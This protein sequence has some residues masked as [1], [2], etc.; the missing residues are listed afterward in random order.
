MSEEKIEQKQ[1]AQT[2]VSEKELKDEKSLKDRVWDSLKTVMEPEMG[3]P[4]VDLGLIYTVETNEGQV[5]IRMTLTSPFCPMTGYMAQLVGDAAQA[6]E[7]VKT[8]E[9]EVVFDPPWDPRT[10]ATEEIKEMMGY[11][12]NNW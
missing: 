6:T 11:G 2:Q 12:S 7:G 3:V 10:M 8:V 4:M 9:V 5:N 1:G